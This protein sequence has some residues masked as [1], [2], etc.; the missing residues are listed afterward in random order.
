MDQTH[1]LGNAGDDFPSIASIFF[2]EASKRKK[3]RQKRDK[4]RKPAD[5][6][7]GKLNA[8]SPELNHG[9]GNETDA[10]AY[11]LLQVSVLELECD[12]ICRERTNS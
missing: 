3:G 5:E 12:A 6:E 7:G 11:L 8:S 10:E 1:R 4:K 9:K 2:R